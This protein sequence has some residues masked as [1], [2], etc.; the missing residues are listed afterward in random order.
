MFWLRL[1]KFIK[2]YFGVFVLL[3][4][5]DYSQLVQGLKEALDVEVRRREVGVVQKVL[6]ARDFKSVLPGCVG[7]GTP[8]IVRDLDTY[9]PYM[10][11]TA[12][13]DTSGINREI[14]VAPIDEDLVVDVSKAKKIADGSLFNVSG[15]NTVNAYW[16]D[17][18]E[19]WVLFST[20]YG[21]PASNVAGVI[22]TDKDFNV[23][24]SQTITFKKADNTDVPLLD[25]GVS[26]LPLYN[27]SVL[28]SAGFADRG[29]FLISDGSV[30]P[31][32]DPTQINYAVVGNSNRPFN[33]IPIHFR[34]SADIHQI[35]LLN[36][37]IV[38]LSELTHNRS[39]WFIQVYYGAQKDWIV[40]TNYIPFVFVA[41][42]L[43]PLPIH[44]TDV[45]G[46]L[47]M[48]HYTNLIKEPY[49]FFVR[50]P[51]WDWGGSRRYAHDIWVT[52]IDPDY[53]FNPIGKVL[54]S[55][56]LTEIRDIPNVIPIPTFGAK[57]IVIYLYG[58]SSNGTLTLTESN[59]PYHIYKQTNI[60]YQTT[61][62]VNT[63]YNK[64]VVDN[65][66]SWISLGLNVDLAEWDVVIY[67]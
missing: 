46:N 20:F 62:S 32:P 6:S 14:W 54:I 56:G 52:R 13:S 45:V 25:G 4:F 51:T 16:D 33:V 26:V 22:F 30:R 21:G 11:F 55:G 2:V 64:I 3:K 35:L 31:L 29:L 59:S 7:V 23:K 61:Y 41:P 9:Q 67:T 50:F 28:L 43:P 37:G 12:W 10:L 5:M 58:V 63:G 53:V 27:K 48:P 17:Y 38:M 24:N 44:F 49:L 8:F 1:V 15:L 40:T 42:I 34:G 60:I 66:A 39:Q 18:N 36:Q 19:Q 65:P 47:G 57:K